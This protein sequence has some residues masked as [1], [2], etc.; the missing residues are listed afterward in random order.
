M[1]RYT[2]VVLA[3]L[4]ATA[5]AV[6]ASWAD[7]LF[8]ELSRDFGSVPRGPTLTHSFRIAN[9][10]G[11]TVHIAGVRVSC[12]CTSAAA[13]Q[14]D[15]EPGQST[16]LVTHMDTRRFGGVKTVT[17]YVQ[18]DR[19]QWEE[20]RLWVQANSRDDLTITPETLAFGHIK[21]GAS[22]ETSVNI[23]FFGNSGWQILDIHCDTS[24][25]LPKIE[26]TRREANEVTYRLSA[27]VRADAPVGRWYTDIWLKTNDPGNIR[28]RVPVTMEIESSLSISPTV[29]SLGTIKAGTETERKIILRGLKPFRITSIEG[30]DAG[31]H[32]KDSTPAS[33]PVHVLTVKLKASVPGDWT[34]TLRVRTDLASDSEIEFQAKA[35]VI[36]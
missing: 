6:A 3:G 15:L 25:V 24:Y 10:T 31:L 32:V 11:E 14:S 23:G 34:R 19:P 17:I 8:D 13:L 1:C 4:W 2:L 7:A 22:P 26:E 18:F 29:A 36:P 33:K 16:A 35:Q 21:R 12:G 5:P 30:T 28:V 27:R 9:K 20:V